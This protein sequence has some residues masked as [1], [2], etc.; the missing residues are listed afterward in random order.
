[1]LID[2][3][4]SKSPLRAC[5]SLCSLDESYGSI[6]KHALLYGLCMDVLSQ[7]HPGFP[8]RFFGD[9]EQQIIHAKVYMKRFNLWSFFGDPDGGWPYTKRPNK[10][11]NGFVL[12]YGHQFESEEIRERLWI[13]FLSKEHFREA[14][15]RFTLG[16]YTTLR[17][18]QYL[19]I[20]SL[21][22]CHL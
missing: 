15:V 13:P 11:E 20:F 2:L 12:Y 8:H 3:T 6:S 22:F 14:L 10:E 4:T 16:T 17:A 7:C 21:L 1:M 9:E 5:F 18:I 19:V